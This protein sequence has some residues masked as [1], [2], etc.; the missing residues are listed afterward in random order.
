MP[1]KQIPHPGTQW[2]VDGVPNE[3]NER[4]A[5]IL[6][7]NKPYVLCLFMKT[8]TVTEFVTWRYDYNEKDYPYFVLGHYFDQDL[9][10][11]L[12]DFE[13]RSAGSHWSI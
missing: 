12:E 6:Q 4:V 9:A 13:V 1:E 8:P 5:V 10:L 7:H 3:Q 11:A 2:F